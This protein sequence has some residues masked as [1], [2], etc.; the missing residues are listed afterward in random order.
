MTRVRWLISG[1]DTRDLTFCFRK[2][3]RAAAILG[4]R[5]L[6]VNERTDTNERTQ[7]VVIPSR[8]QRAPRGKKR[9]NVD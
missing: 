1:G 8:V 4:G 5:P 7:I 3:S 2:A 6:G 9:L